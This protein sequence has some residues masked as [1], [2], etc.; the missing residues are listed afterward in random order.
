M[1]LPDSDS[2]IALQTTSSRNLTDPPGA[3][4]GVFIRIIE[5]LQQTP[6]TAA[7]FCKVAG[8]EDWGREENVRLNS[9]YEAQANVPGTLQDAMDLLSQKRR[10][11]Q[12]SKTLNVP[13]V[14]QY[15]LRIRMVLR[16]YF[17]AI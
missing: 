3:A 4:D 17:T 8:R 2:L 13:I 9:I 7:C 12:V 15:H 11:P 1:V 14:P 6:A 10:I 16:Y 5:P